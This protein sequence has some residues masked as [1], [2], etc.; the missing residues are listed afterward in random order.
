MRSR[1]F[2]GLMKFGLRGVLCYDS[3][4]YFINV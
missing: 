3:F 2:N 4:Q 1:L